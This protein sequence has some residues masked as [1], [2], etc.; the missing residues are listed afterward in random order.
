MFNV[1]TS[2][3]DICVFKRLFKLKQSG[4]IF[5]FFIIIIFLFGLIALVLTCKHLDKKKKILQWFSLQDNW[6]EATVIIVS[7]VYVCV[8]VIYSG[9][10]LFPTLFE[11]GW[12]GWVG[13]G[14]GFTLFLEFLMGRGFCFTSVCMF[15]LDKTSVKSSLRQPFFISYF[16]QMFLFWSWRGLTVCYVSSPPPS[17]IPSLLFL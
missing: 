14:G 6:T 4:H 5:F 3:F 8:G 17:H 7:F 2:L 9:H 1:K 10:D 12:V 16:V 15:H 13:W 11:G